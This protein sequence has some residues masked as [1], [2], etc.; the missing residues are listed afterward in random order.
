MARRALLVGVNQYRSSA[1]PPLRACVSDAINIRNILKTYLGFR[2]EDI[3]ML[4]DERATKANILQRLEWMVDLAR[5]GDFMVFYFAGHGSQVLDRDGDELF[6]QMDEILCP[7]DMNWDNGFILD[8]DLGRIFGRLNGRENVL[9]EVIID[10]CHSGTVL[11]SLDWNDPCIDPGINPCDV[12]YRDRFLQPPADIVSRFEGDVYPLRS[13]A[14]LVS[15]MKNQILWTASREDQKSAEDFFDG[16]PA[17]VFTYFFCKHIRDTGGD[18]TRQELLERIQSSMKF[19]HYSQIPQIE[20]GESGL[21]TDNVLQVRLQEREELRILYLKTPYMRGDDVKSV[22]EALITNGHSIT[23]DGV[24]GPNTHRAVVAFQQQ[25]GLTPDGVV[26]PITRG[27][28][29]Q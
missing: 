28:L 27:T 14:T 13:L 10:S 26:G 18:I 24:F 4:T 1:V 7:Y 11:R 23:A 5:P 3:R 15:D 21:L 22:Q 25:K 19:H 20:T 9:A 2:N 17:G 12:E 29:W 6:D 8:D 16:R